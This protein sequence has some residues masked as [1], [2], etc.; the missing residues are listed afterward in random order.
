MYR[1]VSSAASASPEARQ[2][3]SSADRATACDGEGVLMIPSQSSSE[4]LLH[5]SVAGG[6]SL[7]SAPESG[8]SE[9]GTPGA[10]TPVGR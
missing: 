5:P 6:E 9:A 1:S 8:A 10:A 2:G 7:A 4:P 3:G